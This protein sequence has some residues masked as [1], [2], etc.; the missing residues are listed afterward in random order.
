[1]S[2]AV[3][4]PT[5]GAVDALALDLATGAFVADRAPFAQISDSGIGRDV[6]ALS[7]ERFDRAVGELR[8]RARV[9]WTRTASGEFPF[10][11]RVGGETSWVRVND[12]P[13]DALYTR[14]VDG[15][16]EV[17]L[18]DWPAAWGKPA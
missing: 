11:A 2:A 10:S 16:A 15:A 13:A 17:D 8:A 7:P 3:H 9:A 6:D 1:M 5:G 4:V 18:D 14:V 12:F